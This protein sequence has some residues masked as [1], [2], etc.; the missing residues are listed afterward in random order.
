VD[1][2]ERSIFIVLLGACVGGVVL[3]LARP[4]PLLPAQDKIDPFPRDRVPTVR[5]VMPKASWQRILANPLA[6]Q[7]V[8]AEFWFDGH[9]YPNVAV[10]PKGNSSLRAAAFSGDGRLSFKIDFN[11]L[12]KAQNFCGVKKLSLNNGWSDPTLIR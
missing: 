12:N 1:R 5:I 4:M 6:E 9:R 8:R 7:Y 3:L 2:V 10:R 11:M